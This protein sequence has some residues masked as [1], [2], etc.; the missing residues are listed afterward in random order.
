[1]EKKKNSVQGLQGGHV[2]NL[3]RNRASQKVVGKVS[4]AE[5]I[6]GV[7][8]RSRSYPLVDY[9]DGEQRGR[10]TS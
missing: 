6:S 5:K 7:S 9:E 4:M 2:S 10:R 1:M 8:I 3:G